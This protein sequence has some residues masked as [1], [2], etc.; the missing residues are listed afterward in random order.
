MSFG[1]D[2]MSRV[3][4]LV[5]CVARSGHLEGVADWLTIERGFSWIILSG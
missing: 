2:D 3:T 5:G 1:V 4:K